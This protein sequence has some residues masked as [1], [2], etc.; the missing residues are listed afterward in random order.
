MNTNM[1]IYQV[2]H[3]YGY[4][5]TLQNNTHSSSSRAKHRAVIHL[6]PVCLGINVADIYS[7]LVAKQELFAL[8]VGVDAHIVL[9]RL[10]VGDKRLHDEGVQDASHH[11]HLSRESE[12]DITIDDGDSIRAR[13]TATSTN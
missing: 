3:V 9:V 1:T 5:T 7:A 13:E 6:K 2:Y 4:V 12:S 8:S 10:L 11:F